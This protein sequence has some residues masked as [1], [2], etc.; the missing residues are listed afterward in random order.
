[1]TKNSCFILIQ[2]DGLFLQTFGSYINH[3]LQRIL[4]VS[5]VTEF[6]E[7]YAEAVSLCSEY[8]HK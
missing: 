7:H 5:C 1:M 2:T 8:A 6:P 3:V 4:Y